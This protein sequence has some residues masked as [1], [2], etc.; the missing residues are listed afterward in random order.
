MNT[1]K[2]PVFCAIWCFLALSGLVARAG[3]DSVATL[4]DNLK[5]TDK[6]V[7]V[8]SIDE[9][10]ACGEKAAE[11]V[12][13]LVELLKNDSADV[14]AHAARALGEI[15]S[16]AKSAVNALAGLLK[17]PDET[18]RQQAIKAVVHIRPGPQV[19]IPLC[20]KL[21]EDSDPGVRVRVLHAIAE[22]GPRAVP[23][24]IQALE[25]DN[26]AYW[27]CLVLREIGPPAKDAVPA[28]AEKLQDP[29]PE[30]RREAILALAAMEEA[31]SQ[32]APQ[33]AAAL[34]DEF[35]S[36]AATYALGRIGR[37]PPGIE[38]TIRANINS[39]D[40]VLGV[41]S[42]WTL[43]RVHPENKHLHRAVAERLIRRLKDKDLLVQAAAVRALASL[44]PAPEIIVPLLEEAL[45]DADEATVRNALDALVALGPSA[46][47]RLID[48]LKHEKLRGEV[49]YIL[50]QIG[51]GA[52]AATPA[53]TKLIA[54]KDEQVALEAA[55]ALA[56]IGSNAKGAVPALIETLQE[57]GTKDP[58]AIAYAL[59][60]I[61][62][63][64]V[65][66]EEVLTDLLK[67]SDWKL[68][69]TSAWALVRICPP[70]K[71][72]EE[73]LPVLTAG[74]GADLPLARRGAA[75][76]LGRLG[77]LAKA[78]IPA[79]QKA[80]NDPDAA[81]RSAAEKAIQSIQQ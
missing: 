70:A 1:R 36:Q 21:L 33:I 2:S 63:N 17:D 54:D 31:A 35:T 29:R 76:A 20:V 5:S 11:A 14:R 52:A 81:V 59:G 62:P 71:V 24:L 48:A 16:P 10:G 58:H 41:A 25:N 26:M 77:P 44:P 4:I 49:V 72:S 28:L 65:A 73:T 15:G 56:K 34:N 6:A 80:T 37:I 32:T 78:A 3:E 69:L 75:E 50:G 7:Q 45:Q 23:G 55:V 68:A 39:D 42:L 30:V 27:A 46:V 40:K 79:L 57:P 19:T 66:A 12:A 53:L 22:A 61:G 38:P 9:L 43:A 8:Q 13:P 67:S 47:P 64:A 18:V 60:S 74:L 51:P